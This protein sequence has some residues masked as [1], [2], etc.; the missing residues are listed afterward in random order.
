M[1]KSTPYIIVK[2]LLAL[3]L[4]VQTTSSAWASVVDCCDD[5][6]AACASNESL[7]SCSFCAAALPA[8]SSK[9]VSISMPVSV[10]EILT[11]VTVSVSSGERMIWRPPIELRVS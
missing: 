3:V 10:S 6:Y 4:L 7:G 2:L 9:N 1:R 8:V 11:Y 5:G